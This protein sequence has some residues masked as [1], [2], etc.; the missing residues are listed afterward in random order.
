MPKQKTH[1]QYI[2]ELKDKNI[3]VDV[4]EKYINT[5]TKILHQC[6]KCQ[7][8]WMACP[9]RIL[10]KKD[11]CPICNKGKILNQTEYSK[12]LK[13]KNSNIAVVGTYRN[14][15]EKILH[16]CKV[17]NHEWMASPQ[18]IL[19]DGKCP[20]CSKHKKRT[21]LEYIK[22]LY[23]KHPDIEVKEKFQKM[24]QKILHECK[25]CGYKWFA[26]PH[27][28]LKSSGCPVCIFPPKK[29]GH[30]PEYKNSIWASKYKD[31]FSKFLTEQQMKENM[32]YSNK[33][34]N[35]KCPDCNR[36]K[37]I[38][39]T[40]LL[41]HG[42]SCICR[43]KQSYSNRFMYAFL[44]QLNIKFIPEYSPK[45]ANKK[46]Y[47]IYIPEYNI[48][49]ENHG[50]QHY[51]QFNFFKTTLEKQQENDKQKKELALNNNVQHYIELDCQKSNPSW[52][53]KSILDSDLLKIINIKA[54]IDW[55]DIDKRTTINLVKE[56]ADL[57]NEGYSKSEIEKILNLGHSTVYNYLKKAAMLKM[58]DYTPQKSKKRGKEKYFGKYSY[59]NSIKKDEDT[60][61]K[62]N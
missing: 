12:V 30:P 2:L 18:T 27:D 54:P 1:E 55:I 4:L 60:Y 17:C 5:E 25:K 9:K 34:I 37:E 14:K 53:K 45:W 57:W 19:N 40:D 24:N 20:M 8:K 61:A 26:T 44:Q 50:V 42:L 21:H 11:Y 10:I 47:D 3:D 49:I 29:I 38:M 56:C 16:K 15:K 22:E 59:D 35:V 31:Y 43:N 23:L 28:V 48:I 62:N 32:P 46:R 58:C 41:Q 52:I 33:K 51:K 39:I 7:H 6:K 13:N 36:D